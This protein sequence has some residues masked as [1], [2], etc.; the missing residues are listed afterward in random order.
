[1]GMSGTMRFVFDERA[2]AQAAAYLLRRH[3]EP[4]RSSTLIMLLYLADRRSFIETGYPITGDCFV[5]TPHGPM[6]ARLLDLTVWGAREE[7]SP[8]G[9]LVTAPTDYRV[10]AAGPATGDEL[11]DYGELSEHDRGTLDAVHAEFGGM[12]C[13]A[14]A[15][16]MRSLAEWVEP[17]EGSVDIDPRAVLRD[18]GYTEG[19]IGEV[20]RNVGGIHAFEAKYA[21]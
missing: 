10:A 11:A 12:E 5:A 14:L 2:A 8:W 4:M 19:Q 18:A 16:H 9:E 20:E 17:G 6:L 21:V 3:G 7:D 15:E 13:W 1:M